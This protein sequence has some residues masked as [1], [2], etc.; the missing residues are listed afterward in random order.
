[1]C[2]GVQRGARQIVADRLKRTGRV[3]DEP[4]RKLDETFKAKPII[5]IESHCID[6]R[7]WVRVANRL[8]N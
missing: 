7:A 4:R 5:P 6:S 8:C 1:M 3:D 2:A